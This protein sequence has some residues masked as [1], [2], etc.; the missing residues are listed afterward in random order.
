MSKSPIA[1]DSF[2]F[3]NTKGYKQPFFGCV[4]DPVVCCGVWCC[5]A[6]ALG[7]VTGQMNN[8]GFDVVSCC[9]GGLGA[10]R[11]RKRVQAM[12][13][14]QESDD[15]STC[16]I[17]LCASCA[18]CQDIAEL[19]HRGALK[20]AVVPTTGQQPSGQQQMEQPKA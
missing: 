10:Y 1:E 7:W 12:F 20:S 15:A 14:I 11:L 13:G 9:C 3:M 8:N 5:G 6:L 4:A 2:K 18:V 16:A 17:G 19:K